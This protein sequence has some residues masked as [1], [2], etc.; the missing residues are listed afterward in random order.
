MKAIAYFP[1]QKK[2]RLID[3]LPEPKIETPTHVKVQTLEVGICGTDREVAA[4]AYGEPPP[5]SDF[6]VLG[7]EN[8]GRVVEVGSAVSR[9]KPGDLVV[10]TVRRGC[11]ENCP[12]CAIN[13]SDMCYTGHFTER[14]INRR[15]G[16]SAERYV[17]E[18]QFLSTLPGD[19][20][21][22]G[23]LL[24]PLTISEKAL[25]EISVIQRR[26][27]EARRIEE[28][29]GVS[30]VVG[31]GPVGLMGAFALAAIGAR[32]FIMDIVAHDHPKAK[33]A[34]DAGITYLQGAD[35]MRAV[36]AKHSID[37]MIE[38]T[39]VS[40]LSFDLIQSLGVNGVCVLTGIPGTHGKFDFSGDD[41]MRAMVLK[42]QVLLGSVNANVRSFRRGVAHLAQFQAHF[43]KA[44]G[45][46]I[47]SRWKPE[48]CEEAIFGRR[49]NDI[50]AIIEWAR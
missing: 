48:Q 21:D 47:T 2:L 25:I 34:A 20:R 10:S 9:V 3:D 7:H 11:A 41:L 43:P 13:Q 8:L 19:L 4:G 14:G 12:S 44:V 38:A 32:T 26:L 28:G 49:P 17:E 46:V 22:I 6:L 24:E 27:H 37:A 31:A 1:A 33:I 50:K 18:E 36:A 45:A 40:K 16:F 35:E 15:H 39:G 30:L 29:R 5:G 42:N 23:V